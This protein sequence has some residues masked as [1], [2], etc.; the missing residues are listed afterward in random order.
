MAVVVPDHLVL[1]RL[2]LWGR[3]IFTIMVNTLSGVKCYE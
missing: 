3:V 1:L 2:I